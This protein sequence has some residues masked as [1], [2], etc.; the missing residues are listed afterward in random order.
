MDLLELEI[1]HIVLYDAIAFVVGRGMLVPVPGPVGPTYMGI[2]LQ[3][4]N[5]EFPVVVRSIC[6][7]L[8]EP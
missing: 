7:E 8:T 3:P 1:L 4:P 6:T 2:F 5:H